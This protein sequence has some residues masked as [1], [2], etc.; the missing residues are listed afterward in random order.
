[1]FRFWTTLAVVAALHCGSSALAAEDADEDA[2]PDKIK[3]LLM[4]GQHN[5]KWEETTPVMVEWLEGAGVF[6]VSVNK[7]PWNLKAGDFAPCDVIVSNWSV[8]PNIENDPW[9]AETKAAFEKFMSE[10]GGLVVVH[11]GSSIH[12]QWPEF[13]KMIGATWAKGVTGHGPQHEFEVKFTCEHPITKGMK[14]YKVKDELWHK[15]VRAKSVDVQVLATAFSAKENRGSGADEPMLMT[16]K[17]GKGR[18]VNLVL[19]HDAKSMSCPNFGK[20]LTRS[21]QWAATAD[22]ALRQ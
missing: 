22:V 16:M 13:Q 1:M 10:G 12:Y 5:H 18:C 11:A 9:N 7:E 20:L 4:T 3:V 17:Y 21:V 2:A 19:G 15:M 8:W 14:P 6:D